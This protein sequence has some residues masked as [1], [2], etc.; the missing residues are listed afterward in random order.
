M[1]KTMPAPLNNNN[2]KKSTSNTADPLDDI[3]FDIDKIIAESKNKK[4]NQVDKKPPLDNQNNNS[5]F[6]RQQSKTLN[7]ARK[8]SLV[9]DLFGASTS[10]YKPST[11]QNDKYQTQVSNITNQSDDNIGFGGGGGGYVP[12]MASQTT[13]PRAGRFGIGNNNNN[14]FLFSSNSNNQQRPNTAQT[15]NN[16]SM[17]KTMPFTNNNINDDWLGLSSGGNGTYTAS[18]SGAYTNTQSKMNSNTINNN[19]TS[20]SLDDLLKPRDHSSARPSIIII[21]IIL[22]ITI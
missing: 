4:Q 14:D 8:S 9:E 16:N 6:E 19:K 1:S 10:N 21:I 5:T 2:N 12:S 3:D 17:A 13:T 22:L 11:T 15:G 18:E 7:Q 20:P